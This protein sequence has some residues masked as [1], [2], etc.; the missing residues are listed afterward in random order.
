MCQTLSTSLFLFQPTFELCFR[1]PLLHFQTTWTWKPW[2]TWFIC[3]LLTSW[4]A[5][6][7]EVVWPSDRFKDEQ[8]RFQ[9]HIQELYFRRSGLAHF[10][11]NIKGSSDLSWSHAR[12]IQD[13]T[14]R[15]P[16]LDKEKYHNVGRQILRGVIVVMGP[17]IRTRHAW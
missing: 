8:W 1:L 6:L 7:P 12:K 14:M 17:M 15:S 13:L 11:S 9:T 3:C 2:M 4:I 16:S 5:G 10:N